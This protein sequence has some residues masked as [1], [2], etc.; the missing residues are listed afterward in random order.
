LKKVW[1]PAVWNSGIRLH[2]QLQDRREMV[3]VLGQRVELEI[4]RMP[5][6]PQGLA[7]GS[8]APIIILP[9]SDL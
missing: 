5:P 9:A 8:K 1:I 2:R 6:M 7:T 4:R 3:P